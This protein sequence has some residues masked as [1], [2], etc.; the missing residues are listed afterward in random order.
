MGDGS[1][2]SADRLAGSGGRAV[3]PQRAVRG[4]LE[5]EPTEILLTYQR[6]NTFYQIG[7]RLVTAI[8]TAPR[9]TGAETERNR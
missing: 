1:D 8:D 7:S 9:S 2:L 6:R 3:D 4:R 5:R